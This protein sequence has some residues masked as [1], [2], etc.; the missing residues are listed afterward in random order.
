MEITLCPTVANLVPAL[1]LLYSTLA[2]LICHPCESKPPRM[3]W[4]REEKPRII[5]K[6]PSPPHHSPLVLKRHVNG[7]IN[8]INPTTP[9]LLLPHS[10]CRLVNLWTSS[11]RPLNWIPNKNHQIINLTNLSDNSSKE[12]LIC[13]L[14]HIFGRINIYGSHSI[15]SITPPPFASSRPT[16]WLVVVAIWQGG[17]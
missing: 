11:K 16:V 10:P 8:V 4:M 1:I 3:L 17:W 15:R 9:L 13:D 12:E 7:K 6:C 14:F 2:V 5:T